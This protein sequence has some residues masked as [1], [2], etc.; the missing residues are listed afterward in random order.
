MIYSDVAA[1]LADPGT[2]N[3]GAYLWAIDKRIQ[4]GQVK[5][6]LVI[7]LASLKENVLEE[8]RVQV[9]HLRGVVLKNSATA[10]SVIN[11]KYKV[12]KKNIDYDIYIY[13]Y[14]SM[15]RME[16][17]LPDGY[18]DMVI[19]DEAHRIGNPT[20]RQ[21]K[22]IV[23]LFD[24]AKYK[25]IITATLHAN[26]LIS[27]FMPFRFLGPDTIPY[28]NWMEFR[29]RF[30]YS[31]DPD[32]HIWIPSPGSADEVTKIT[33][34]ISVMFKKEECLDLPELITE[35][36]S[37]SMDPEQEKLYA[38][39]KK[40]LIA[41]I[42][43]MCSK[44]NKRGN[45]DMSCRDS[46]SA[47]NSLVLLTKLRQICCGFY[48]NTKITFSE[49]GK[50]TNE[51]NII[52]LPKNP[53]LDLMASIISCIPKDRKVIVWSTYVHAIELIRDRLKNAFG[54]DCVLTCYRNQN[55]Y[56]MVQKFKEDKYKFMVAMIS[57]MGVGQNMQFSNYQIFF[58]NS[59]S[60]IQREQAVG[61]QHRQGQTE[62]VTVFDIVMR[63]SIDEVVLASLAGKKDM[64]ITLSRL[65]VVIQK[66][67]FDPEK[68]CN[69]IL[70]SED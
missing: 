58:N 38:Q 25:Y 59:Y 8:M 7:T 64:S 56:E 10:D 67:G 68:D 51:S 9:P 36:I 32:G 34:K 11:K 45:C 20:S 2:C 23:R 24:Y 50:Q 31:V 69:S 63:D 54:C 39:M 60:Y 46:V 4:R 43:D 16:E 37:C 53:K 6:A 13:N 47:K 41:M 70:L 18:F 5:K 1:I 27:F 42:D 33:G 48:I 35:K 29:R 57:K 28:A 49:S 19:L 15:F 61:R 21:S 30:M 12:N 44:C 65:S 22:A 14:E 40:D 55:A 17:F 66:G 52:T 3:T 62:K 26:N